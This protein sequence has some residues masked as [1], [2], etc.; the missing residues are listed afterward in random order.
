VDA[1]DFELLEPAEAVEL[2]PPEPAPPKAPYPDD[3]AAAVPPA[4]AD[5]EVE[6]A[7]TRVGS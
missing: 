1:P 2:A 4:V 7:F 6:V 5:E 3:V